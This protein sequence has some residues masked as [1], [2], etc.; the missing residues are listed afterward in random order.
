MLRS[1]L[2]GLDGSAFSD[3]AVELGVRWARRFDALLV[4][5]G[6]ID[7][8]TITRAEP[9]PLGAGYYKEHL[10]EAR[11]G[12]ARRH[13]E[14]FLEKFTLA[15]SKEGVSAKLLED[16]GVPHEQIMLEAQRYDLVLL[17]Q[18]TH[19]HFLTQETA[20][21]TLQKVL[22]NTP[23]PVVVV[24]QQVPPA[25][26]VVVAYDGSLQAARALQSFQTSGLA[27]DREVHIVSIDSTHD[28]A[29][30]R[31]GRA[32]EFL[33]FHDIKAHTHPIATSASPAGVLLDQIAKLNAGLLVMGAYGQPTLREFLLGSVTRTLLKDAKIP[34]FLYH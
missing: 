16:V 7:A 26:A 3:A 2:I 25:G 30:R 9:L 21:E 34:L 8:P 27:A 17:G 10:D 24:P 28:G 33:G 22:H 15:C 12:R 11:L 23:R 19:F 20:C 29:D 5:M 14:Q 18:E 6:V 4:G 32:V 13:V 1:I 31:A